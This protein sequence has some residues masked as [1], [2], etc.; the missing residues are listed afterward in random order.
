[1]VSVDTWLAR[2]PDPATDPMPGMAEAGLLDGREATTHWAYKGLLEQYANV[3]VETRTATPPTASGS[4][5]E[6][7]P[8]RTVLPEPR[9]SPSLDSTTPLPRN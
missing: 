7:T 2:C 1:M 8:V 4:Q 3:E 5:V 9:P 6:Q